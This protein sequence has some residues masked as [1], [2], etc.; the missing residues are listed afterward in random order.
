MNKYPV[1]YKGKEYEVRW[2]IIGIHKHLTIYEVKERNILN[3]IKRKTYIRKYYNYSFCVQELIAIPDDDPNYH[4]E[5]VKTLFKMWETELQEEENE[6]NIKRKKMQA[7]AE[8]DGVI[9][10]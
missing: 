7:L 1:I 5:E 6:N 2:E 4:I 9:D 10:E 3:I 8:W